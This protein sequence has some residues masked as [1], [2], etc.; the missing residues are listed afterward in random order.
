MFCSPLSPTVSKASAGVMEIMPVFSIS[1]MKNFLS[2]AQEHGWSILG[3]SGFPTVNGSS[4]K[5]VNANK[6]VNAKKQ[7]QEEQK[8]LKTM[9]CQEY[10]KNSPVLLIVGKGHLQYV[11]FLITAVEPL[12]VDFPTRK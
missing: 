7:K 4:S 12:I 5:V 3:T 11:D 6:P 9:N 10:V 8:A 2:S 1:H